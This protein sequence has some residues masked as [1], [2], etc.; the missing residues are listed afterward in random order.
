MSHL[1]EGTDLK[2]VAM[3]RPFSG[4]EFVEANFSGSPPIRKLFSTARCHQAE[5][6][7][8][9]RV[10]ANGHVAEENEDLRRF[11]AGFVQQDLIRISFWKGK[12]QEGDTLESRKCVG[13]AILK[14]DLIPSANW[15]RW[16]VYEAVIRTYPHPHNYANAAAP[17]QFRC[18]RQTIEIRGCLYAQQ[19]SVTKTCAQVAI[20]SLACT[21]SANN[22]LSYRTINAEATLINP[23]FRPEEGMTND[24]IANVLRAL[25]INVLTLDYSQLD[26]TVREILPYQKLVYSGIESGC[27]ALVAFELSGPMAPAAGH[28]IPFFG[29]TFNEDS[30]APTGG[31]A[32]FQYGEHIRYISSRAWLSSFL[33][34][35]DNF[36]ANLCVPQNFLNKD[37]ISCVYEILPPG[38]NCSGVDAEVA[39]ADYFYSILPN[40]SPSAAIPWRRR[41]WEYVRDQRLILRHVPITKV[42]Y[43]EH[44]RRLEDWE[45]RTEDQKTIKAFEN[46]VSGDKYWMVEVSVPEVFP[47]NKRK[48]GE[49]LLEASAP[50]SVQ[51]DGS[52][53]VLARFPGAFV[54][55][56]QLDANGDPT[57]ALSPSNLYSHVP[58]YS[59]LP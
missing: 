40:L 3:A 41:L 53:F 19:N 31:P 28:V 25:G 57:F 33:V 39:A 44:L 2:Y 14:H 45:F 23:S 34:H 15:D 37:L 50:L 56:D 6:L 47:T 29:H 38:W 32:Y 58:L 51:T 21:I 27:G 35:D 52:G 42:N 36:G 54:F 7:V 12:I 55:F 48:L 43:L 59:T 1:V 16:H 24:E 18:G 11:D 8:F 46:S 4:F 13:Y 9:E 10:P 22:D 26:P 5:S 49:I 30:W 17:F 20:R